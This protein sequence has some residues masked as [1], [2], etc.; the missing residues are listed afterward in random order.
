MLKCIS[1]YLSVYCVM[2]TM[3][4]FHGHADVLRLVTRSSPRSPRGGTRDK[5]KRLMLAFHADVLR[6]VL[7]LLKH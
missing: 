5:P 4:A 3:V 1:E 2:S 7:F 6:L